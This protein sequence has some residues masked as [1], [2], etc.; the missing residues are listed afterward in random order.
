MREVLS[1][2]I[3]QAGVQMGNCC[4]ELY[5][6]EHGL[7]EKG[8]LLDPTEISHSKMRISDI[9]STI[10]DTTGIPDG[11]SSF[12]SETV[13]G[14]YTPRSIFVDMDPTVI[15]EIRTGRYK[16]LHTPS[17]LISGQEDAANNYA[18]AHHTAGE[19]IWPKT[20]EAIRKTVENC[21]RF[22]GFMLTHSLGGG[23]GSG[24]YAKMLEHAADEFSKNP[25]MEVVIFPC[26]KLS[27]AVVEPYNA[28]LATHA[29]LDKTDC[30]F[31]V[32][33]EA[34]YSICRTR[35]SVDSPSYN[36]LNRILAQAISSI[37]ASIRFKG[38]LNADFKDFPTNLV[39]FPRIHFPLM[40]YAPIVSPTAAQ[41]EMLSILDITS[42]C[43]DPS[44]IMMQ[45]K[46]DGG[47]YVACC[48]LYR[49]DVVPK[50]INS[51]IS[52]IRSKRTLKFVDWSPTGF[53]IGINSSIPVVVQ[54]GDLARTMRSV[55][56]LGN[57][58]AVKEAWSNLN[59]K[60]H[61]MLEK[62]AFVHW[63][64]QEGLLDSEFYEAQDDLLEL[65]QEYD[66]MNT[67]E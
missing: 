42:K 11:F 29:S 64:R 59:V 63:Y 34:L 30:V 31:L 41:H 5:C 26:P 15:D 21:E 51:A 56:M 28:I 9:S 46:E 57:T 65:E 50:E 45:C 62:K 48:L 60:Y 37:T 23:T 33:N 61:V 43:F 55:C 18:R 66:I 8:N 6:L 10:G 20:Q 49:G 54:G 25:K 35:L 13:I 7:D 32:N 17:N 39:P 3:G 12:F 36:N 19:A 27:T 2:H 14:A 16:M 40:S 47:R 1:I 58:T 38:S 44:S 52:S 22:E 24:Y 4:W 67:D 53:K